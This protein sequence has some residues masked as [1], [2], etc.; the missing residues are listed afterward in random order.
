MRNAGLRGTAAVA[1]APH[2]S[3]ESEPAVTDSSDFSSSE[4]DLQ[5]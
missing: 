1:T 2:V 5:M 3:L 4:S